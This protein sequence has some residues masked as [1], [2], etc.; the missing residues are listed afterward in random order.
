MQP[1]WRWAA[2]W[3][4]HRP[5]SRA[6]DLVSPSGLAF[7]ANPTPRVL[8]LS[9][10]SGRI[11]R[12]D[13]GL[14]TTGTFGV[15]SAGAEFRHRNIWGSRRFLAPG[16]RPSCRSTTPGR[17]LRGRRH[18]DVRQR[19]RLFRGRRRRDPGSGAQARPRERV[20][21]STKAT[22]RKGEGVN[23]VGSSRHYLIR[24]VEA[25]LRRLGTDYIDL[26]QLHGFDAVTPVEETLRRSTT[27]CAPARC[28]TSACSNFSGWHLMKS[29][30]G[31]RELRLA[32]LRRAPGLLL[33]G[34]TRLRVGA[35][36]ARARPEG[37]RGGVEPAGLGAL[38][39]KMR[40]GSPCRPRAACT[41]PRACGPGGR[42][43]LF[44]V[45]DA[46]DEVAKETGKTVPQVALNWLLQRP[47]VAKVVRRRP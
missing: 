29:L 25:A 46:L 23:D 19:R 11:E 6:V 10:R 31:R 37:G 47:T 34:R 5:S 3:L 30:G 22:F 33:A 42:G 36:A 35:D 28:A 7:P 39:R 16:A 40:R 12:S 45:V 1:P 38:D 2:W 4:C 44:R 21:I 20:L 13:D 27:S 18:H 41:R 32:A 14:Q 24:S 8:D 15:E 17:H 26:F 9:L 43:D